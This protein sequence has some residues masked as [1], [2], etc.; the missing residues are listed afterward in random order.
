M[1]FRWTTATAPFTDLDGDG[2]A[3][4]ALEQVD[5]VA[6][7]LLVP[8]RWRSPDGTAVAVTPER[9]GVTDLATIQTSLTWFVTRYGRHT[10]AALLHDQLVREASTTAERSR[11][12]RAFGQAMADLGVPPV[13]RLVMSSAVTLAT[14]W[15]A[16][17]W[18]RRGVAVWGAVSAAGM[19]LLVHG[20]VARRRGEVVV[21]L[22]GPVAAAPLWGRD[23]AIGIVGGYAVWLL[24]VPTATSFVGYGAYWLLEQAVRQARQLLS[25]R[26]APMPPGPVPFGETT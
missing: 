1:T 14:R 19:A 18:S 25:H 10:P 8:F 23:A 11:A 21:A 13:R 20:L 7:R 16:G 4:F 26:G 3:R 6:F 15:A 2:P 22:V 9:L 17:G 24:V 12:D 5:D